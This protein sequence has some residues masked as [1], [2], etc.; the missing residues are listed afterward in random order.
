M[1]VQRRSEAQRHGI[2]EGLGQRLGIGEATAALAVQAESTDIGVW[3]AHLA[4]VH[5]VRQVFA[6]VAPYRALVR[7]FAE[8]CGCTVRVIPPVAG[9]APRRSCPARTEETPDGDHVEYGD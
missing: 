7:S 3:D 9:G 4:V 1:D 2:D 6:H 5:T 8:A